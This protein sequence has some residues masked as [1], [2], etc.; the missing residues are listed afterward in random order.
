MLL[1]QPT[2]CLPGVGPKL[3]ALLTKCGIHS[4]QDLLFHLPFRYQDRTR[5][6]PI[7]DLRDQ[8]WAVIQGTIINQHSHRSRRPQLICTLQDQSH[9]LTLRFFH[10]NT[11]LKQAFA[12]GTSL[13]A[14]G[15][16][17]F[18][19]GQFEMV[20]P[21]CHVINADQ[22][23]GMDET[24]TP[25]YSVTQ[26][27]SQG[28]LRQLTQYAL[29][30]LKTSPSIEILPTALVEAIDLPPIKD[31]LEYLHHPPPDAN[32][33]LIEEGQHPAQL[34]LAFEELLAHHVSMMRLRQNL[35][36]Y[37]SRPL[38]QDPA[39]KSRL[40]GSLPFSLTEGQS[41]VV[42]E[43]ERDLSLNTP[44]YRL[45]QG[46]VGA[47]KTL[48]AA[49]SCLPA[50]AASTQ[51]ALMA[52]T[53]LLARQ[54]HDTF[55]RLL[56]PLG[57]SVALLTGK[58]T[59]KTKRAI[60]TKIAD[61]DIQVVIGTHALFQKALQF[62]ELSFIIIDEQH[63]F[64]VKQRA[65]LQTKGKKGDILPHQLVMTATPIPRTLAMTQY[66]HLSL[67]VIDTLPPGR[68]PIQTTVLANDKR[69]LLID[70]LSRA[71]KEQKQAYWVCTLIEESETLECQN[72]EDTAELLRSELNGFRIGLVHGRMKADDKNNVMAAFANH[73]LDLLVATTV[74]E[75]GVDVPN[76]S[77]MIIE[78]AE[79]FGLAQ[80]HQLRGRVGRGN[81]QS[82]CLLLYQAPLSQEAQKRL[83]LIREST[84]GFYI[85][86]ED[87]KLRGGGEV[88]GTKQTGLMHLKIAHLQKHQSLINQLP[89]A[90]KHLSNQAD[91]ETKLIARWL[92]DKEKFV[93][94]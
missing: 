58:Q 12:V 44:M 18:K 70:R 89:Q 13:R 33:T 21:E 63:R 61:G 66:A 73:E 4:V 49:L 71:F 22:P 56:S 62:K 40:I 59:T 67:S 38:H 86:E 20:H 27:L 2:T 94:S 64:G 6:T 91:I 35:K 41:R 43:I 84:D 47:G 9:Y 10:F 8:D 37:K 30:R 1:E 19:K 29:E 80:L 57:I 76:A 5:L 24:L 93:T 31:C 81:T 79:R 85:A 75:V 90:I 53:E 15:E 69:G 45:L 14:F 55:E 34:R 51:I 60:Q 39:L 32:L 77:L 87:L 72:A 36:A 26:G 52:P 7:T 28:R 50:I 23:V 92:G 83:S 17:R 68:T 11:S 74:I 78:N 25:I 54:H 16:V 82:H 3:A 88:I 65:E 46:D 48:V 42:K